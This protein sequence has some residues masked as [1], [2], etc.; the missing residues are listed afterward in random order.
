MTQDPPDPKSVERGHQ[1]V[2]VNTRLVI[3][4]GVLFVIA[5]AVLH[6]ALAGLF[7]SFQRQEARADR[8]GSPFLEARPS[9]PPPRLQ[10]APAGELEVYQATQ[11]A[12]LNGYGWVDRDAGVVHIPI[13]RAMDL[14][15]LRGVPAGTGTPAPTGTPGAP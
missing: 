10:A 7:F 5:A 4:L 14:L 9:P 2:E 11:Q 15:V 6:L 12:R 13:D 3:G 8:P 1:P